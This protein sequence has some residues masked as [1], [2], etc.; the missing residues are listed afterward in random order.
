MATASPAR[1]AAD[2]P[3]LRLGV[4]EEDEEELLASPVAVAPAAAASPPPA[5]GSASDDDSGCRVVWA[6]GRAAAAAAKT[7]IQA[8]ATA[9]EQQAEAAADADALRAR[10]SERFRGGD[11]AGALALYS[12]A[13][14]LLET[15]DGGG[16]DAQ[17]EL[18]AVLHGNASAALLRLG[19][20]A[21]AAAAA[22][23]AA[24]AAPAAPKPLFRLAEAQA[25]A[26]R[27]GAAA[28]AARRGEA[29]CRPSAEGR[30]EFSPLLD[31]IAVA[32]AAAG[33]P[34]GYDGRR[35]E[36][37]P[38]GAEAWLGRPAP[39]VPALDGPLDDD[40]ALPGD[41]LDGDGG[42]G[43]EEPRT[44]PAPGG[45][46]SGAAVGGGA[47]AAPTKKLPLAAALPPPAPAGDALATWSAA[48]VAAAAARRVRT[49]FRCLREA[50]A[51]ARDGDRILLRAGVHNGLGESVEVSRRVLIEGE[52]GGGGGG[53]H[54]A[55]ID[56]RANAPTFRV[57][58]AGATLCGFEL[59]QV[60]FRE[61]LLVTSPGAGAG[62]RSKGPAS[63][64]PGNAGL[65]LARGALL[66]DLTVKCSGDD[67]V[68]VSGHAAPRF[69]RCA[70]GGK[71]AGLRAAGAAAPRLDACALEG[72]G[73]QGVAAQELAAVT[74][75]DCVI[76]DCGAEGVMAMSGASARLERCV[77]TGCKGP[78]A[79]A[80]GAA[81]L[82]VAGGSIAGCVGGVFLWGGAAAELRSAALGGGRANALLLDGAAAVDARRC[83]VQGA[84]HAP[85]AAW[86]AGLLAEGRDNEFESPAAATD[87]PPEAGPFRFEPSPYVRR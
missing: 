27:W 54:A 12:E 34:A 1:P 46:A 35:L 7:S 52:G 2:P 9:T 84:V 36:V 19:R 40:S 77:I 14:A 22:L 37:R 58:A 61:A 42:S 26:R 82:A 62:S 78:G 86:D 23:R 28:A 41:D 60:G 76:K 51:A 55:V 4:M 74:L 79:D 68:H 71:R 69:V 44:L 33:S 31:A 15:D 80:S 64:F 30:T 21:E 18:L 75:A 70:L 20:P 81:R 45:D 67:G 29:L 10:G 56:Q 50:L 73:E 32:A 48:R 85:D 3:I 63:R 66:M 11:H 16:I 65:E 17:P 8:P 59:D 87:F 72:C 57:T 43:A 49:S 25:A 5:G 47:L 38:A 53:K 24:A 6:S 83:R 39:H 13:A